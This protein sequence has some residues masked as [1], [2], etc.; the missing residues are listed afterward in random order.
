MSRA[1]QIKGPGKFE[2]ETYAVRWVYDQ[3]GHG[4]LDDV[5]S[6]DELGWYAKYS[7]KIKGRGP[8][9]VIIN[10]DSQGF[11]SGEFFDTDKQINKAW[12]RIEKEYED[13]Y[14]EQGDDY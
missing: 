11:V 10:E 9:H 5:G 8:F 4:F 2:G 1:N 6:V 13:F 14:A 7:G 12:E 3:A